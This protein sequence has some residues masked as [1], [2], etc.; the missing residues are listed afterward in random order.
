MCTFQCIA[1]E[2]ASEMHERLVPGRVIPWLFCISFFG[3]KGKFW[4]VIMAEIR[5]KSATDLVHSFTVEP[6]FYNHL[7]VPVIDSEII[8]GRKT[9]VI[10][11]IKCYIGTIISG[12]K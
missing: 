1:L 2:N 9:R 3:R 4:F 12:H 5:R 6:V 7:L 11:K 8:D 10:F